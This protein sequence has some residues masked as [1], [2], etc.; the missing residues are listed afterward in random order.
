MEEGRA[1]PNRR[2]PTRR[3]SV[4]RMI[5]LVIRR[6]ASEPDCRRFD[7]YCIVDGREYDLA[8]SALSLEKATEEI[9]RTARRLFGDS[10]VLRYA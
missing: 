1:Y 8:P 9:E 3:E 10:I 5:I 2:L 7:F 4:F 6:D